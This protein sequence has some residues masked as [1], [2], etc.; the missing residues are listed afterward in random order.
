[1]RLN[2]ELDASSM[3]NPQERLIKSS[4]HALIGNGKAEESILDLLQSLASRT[5]RTCEESTTTIRRNEALEELVG[6][7][8][9]GTLTRGT[10]PCLSI[11]VPTPP[12][13]DDRL[14]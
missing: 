2:F 1:M 8:K 12:P 13:D 11:E 10:T 3:P 5:S 14:T 7:I 6:L 9:V 4:T